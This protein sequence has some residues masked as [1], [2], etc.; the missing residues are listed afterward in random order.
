MI[1][2]RRLKEQMNTYV[3]HDK[4]YSLPPQIISV[5]EFE[6]LLNFRI[7]L[8]RQLDEYI[9]SLPLPV[10]TI[11]YEELLTDELNTM[12]RIYEFIGVPFKP[13]QGRCI[14]ITSD[15]LRRAVKNF[16]EL[17][18]HYHGTPYEQ[19]FDEVLVP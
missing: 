1:N 7:V 15:D 11:Y 4:T 12:K 19:M 16:E 10:L 18:S 13:T 2:F 5:E 14:K 9:K 3:L 8:D 17:R 6:R